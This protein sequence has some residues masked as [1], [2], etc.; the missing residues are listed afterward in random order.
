[1]WLCPLL[2]KLNK[3]QVSVRSLFVWLAP[4]AS[5]S[6]VKLTIANSTLGLNGVVWLISR[7]RHTCFR[8]HGTVTQHTSIVGL[9]TLCHSKSLTDFRPEGGN[10][11]CTSKSWSKQRL[12]NNEAT[13][14]HS[15]EAQLRRDGDKTK[16]NRCREGASSSKRHEMARAPI[17]ALFLPLNF[18]PFPYWNIFT[19]VTLHTELQQIRGVASSTKYETHAACCYSKPHSASTPCKITVMF[20]YGLARGVL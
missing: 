19:A 13:S 12:S 4:L 1:M 8:R 15:Q 18:S 6:P 3:L 9:L 7:T 14:A 11:G 17:S 10:P 20:L 16:Q 5:Q 2:T